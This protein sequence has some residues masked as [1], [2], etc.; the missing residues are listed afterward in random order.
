ME[1]CVIYE[2]NMYVSHIGDSRIYVVS[3]EYIKQ[4]TIDDTYV[5]KLIEEGT[6]TREEAIHHPDKHML[7]KA[8]GCDEIIEPN[9]FAREWQENESILICSDGL[10]N[11]L[12]NE[13]IKYIILNELLPEKKLI[14]MANNAGGT[15]NITTIIIKH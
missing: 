9:I 12:N 14:D 8:L 5:E 1:L 4:I 6:I 7:T 10:T 15:D 11:M 3:E 2:N 13:E